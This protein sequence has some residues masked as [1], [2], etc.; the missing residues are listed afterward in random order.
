MSSRCLDERV[1]WDMS[2]SL[3]RSGGHDPTD[4][5]ENGVGHQ[6]WRNQ[7]DLVPGRWWFV[8][9]RPSHVDRFAVSVCAELRMGVVS[10][11][12]VGAAR[13]SLET[14]G[15]AAGATVVPTTDIAVAQRL[16]TNGVAVGRD[17]VR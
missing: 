4:V 12:E 14:D 5:T 8:A 11:G 9:S 7:L 3:A 16:F 15:D 2:G 13:A 6:F 10:R 17:P 1:A